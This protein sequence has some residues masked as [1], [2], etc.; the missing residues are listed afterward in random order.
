MALVGEGIGASMNVR[1]F[2]FGPLVAASVIAIVA[3]TACGSDN[4][5]GQDTSAPPPASAS[6]PSAADETAVRGLL[7]KINE[8]WARGD[9]TAY[10]SFHT[11]DADLIDFRGTHAAGRQ[12]IIDLLQPAFDGVL[13]NSR[14]EARIVDLR[15]LASDV[16][17]FH[18]EGKIVP[19]GD[20]S[21]QTFVATK[22][23]DG[24]L[25]AAFQNTRIQAGG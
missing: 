18:T 1:R 24:W 15:F 21:I 22:G 2:R 3:S 7:D 19:M 8:A 14:V 11:A 5:A 17:V 16:A 13:K 4:G 10:A 6:V 12:A 25:I 23:P 20:N 9:A